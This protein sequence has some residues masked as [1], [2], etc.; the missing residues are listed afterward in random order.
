MLCIADLRGQRQRV[1]CGLSNTAS[2]CGGCGG[3]ETLCGGECHWLEQANFC[4]H[5]EGNT[6]NTPL[7][8]NIKILVHMAPPFM[9]LSSSGPTGKKFPRAMGVYSLSQIS[10]VSH[11][12]VGYSLLH[13]TN[14]T[15]DQE[16]DDFYIFKDYKD[17][18]TEFVSRV[19]FSTD[20]EDLILFYNVTGWFMKYQRFNGR[21]EFVKDP[22]VTLAAMESTE[23][24]GKACSEGDCLRVHYCRLQVQ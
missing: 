17:Q 18:S 24:H 1:D 5:I 13:D 19:P 20:E 8:Y 12:L 6:P 9:S 2:H 15:V 14:N 11:L 21:T 16:P 4:V 22:T 10:N 23:E 3:G 7:S